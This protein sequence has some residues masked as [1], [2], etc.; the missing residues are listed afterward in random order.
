MIAAVQYVATYHTFGGEGLTLGDLYKKLASTSEQTPLCYQ[1][2][3]GFLHTTGG[4]CI[5]FMPHLARSRMGKSPRAGW[6]RVPTS[7][8]AHV[9]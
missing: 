8:C 3:A 9:E 4:W 7:H 1:K 5:N 2:M 6:E